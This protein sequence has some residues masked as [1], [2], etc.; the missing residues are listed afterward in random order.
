LTAKTILA[1]FGDTQIGSST[2][3]APPKFTIHNNDPKETQVVEHNRLQSWLW[4]SWV[5]Y[6][7]YIKVL[8]GVRGRNRK[9][10]IVVVH[11]GDVIDGN[12][13]GTLQI[14][15]DIDD[16]KIA[17]KDILNPIADMADAF[18]GILGTEAHAG[19]NSEDEIDLYKDLSV[20]EYGQNLTIKVDGKIH[21]FAH[22]GRVGGRGWTS[23]AASIG[24]EVLLDYGSLGMP[25]PDYIWRAH[26]HVIDDSGDKLPGTRV[27]CLPSW[28]LKTSFVHRL[29]ANRVRSDIGG[30]I[31]DG[32]VVDNSRSRYKGQPNGRRIIEL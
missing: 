16:Q 10:R 14:M 4:D 9:N 17:A 26:N 21:D 7:D 5:D 23:A 6:W 20:T 22:H 30:Y 27:I 3:L 19:Q 15:A 12:H 32:G 24:V 2:A 1:V 18:F 29:T 28:Q 13:H 31:V 11:M 8:A 25:F